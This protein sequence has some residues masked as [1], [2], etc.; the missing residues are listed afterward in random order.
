MRK[1][2]IDPQSSQLVKAPTF[3]DKVKDFFKRIWNFIMSPTNPRESIFQWIVRQFILS[4]SKGNPSWTITLAVVIIVYLGISIKTEL[5]V[6]LSTVKTYDPATGN[7][8]S[9]GMKGISESFWYMLIV[10]YSAVTY[11]FQQ[12]SNQTNPT[13]GSGSGSI[14]DTIINTASDALGKI[15][16]K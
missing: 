10:A 11:L 13:A 3:W 8:I 7:L 6:A 4:D 16:G 2:V 5:T 14:V 1:K 15:K 12:R 9:E